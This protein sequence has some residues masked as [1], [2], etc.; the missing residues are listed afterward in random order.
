M[1]TH[2]YLHKDKT[3]LKLTGEKPADFLNDLLTAQI[4]ELP[5][6]IARAACLLSPQGR[7]LFDMLVVQNDGAVYLVTEKAQ[8]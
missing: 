5:A 4:A 1:S 3:A 2:L 7:I 8:A 6:G